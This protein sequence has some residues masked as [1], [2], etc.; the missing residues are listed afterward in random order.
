MNPYRFYDD[1]FWGISPTVGVRYFSYNC[2]KASCSSQGFLFSVSISFF[3]LKY[4]SYF[5]FFLIIVV[6]QMKE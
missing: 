5:F 3:F 1:R 4:F 2:G 6:L